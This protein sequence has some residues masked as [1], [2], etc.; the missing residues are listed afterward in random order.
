M[1]YLKA[2]AMV[3]CLA[4]LSAGPV[5]AQ[6]DTFSFDD[7]ALLGQVT[8]PAASIVVPSDNGVLNA[9]LTAGEG[10][11][12]G[13]AEAPAIPANSPIS[14]QLVWGGRPYP[15]DSAMIGSSVLTITLDQAVTDLSFDFIIGGF[16]VAPDGTGTP[17]PE[18]LTVALGLGG[19]TTDVATLDG[20]NNGFDWYQGSSGALGLGGSLFDTIVLT[21]GGPNSSNVELGID[22][23]VV[24]GPGP[25]P[26]PEPG[27]LAFLLGGLAPLALRLRRKA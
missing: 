16:I 14:G 1:K 13:F 17:T 7:P 22:N 5:L 20:V 21:G 24:R 8:P 2:L 26:V 15:D 11:Q 23:L 6:S 10:T 9:T 4:A 19:G 3:G 25:T 27:T 12:F 18:T